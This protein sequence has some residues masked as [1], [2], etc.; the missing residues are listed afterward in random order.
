MTNLAQKKAQGTVRTAIP[1]VDIYETE[2]EFVIEAEV[3]GTAKDRI[4]VELEKDVLEVKAEAQHG[5]E[6]VTYVR[7]F[8]VGQ[9]VNNEK[10]EA[11]YKDGLVRLNLPKAENQKPRTISVTG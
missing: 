11:N 2:G 1:S 3:P 9:S 8:K 6:K 5:S 7:R 10:I 4:A